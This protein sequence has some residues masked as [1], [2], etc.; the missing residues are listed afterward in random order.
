MGE[1]LCSHFLGSWL[2]SIPCCYGMAIPLS[3]W[4]PARSH[5]EFPKS[6]TLPDSDALPPSASPHLLVPSHLPSVPSPLY[7]SLADSSVFWF[8]SY[9]FRRLNWSYPDNQDSFL[10]YRKFFQST[11]LAFDCKKEWK[12]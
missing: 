7:S 2:S 3:T 4:L 8:S 9:R 11:T 5:S 10:P 1:N 6:P 12:S